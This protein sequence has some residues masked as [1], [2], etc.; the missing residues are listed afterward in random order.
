M[1]TTLSHD[2]HSL[3]VFGRDPSDMA[4]AA[5]AVISARGGVAVARDGEVVSILEL[6]VAGIL[7]P[8]PATEVARLQGEVGAAAEAIGLPPGPLTQPLFSVMLMSLACLTGP[9]VTDI[10]VVD[11]TLGQLVDDLVLA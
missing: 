8:L 2:T 1:A 7:S 9:H 3:A 10:G 6:P 11:G 5:N 4:V